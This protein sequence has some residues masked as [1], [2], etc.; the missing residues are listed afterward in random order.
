MQEQT[1]APALRHQPVGRRQRHH[2]QRQSQRSAQERDHLNE[3]KNG[4]AQSVSKN[5]VNEPS[6]AKASRVLLARDCNLELLL[7]FLNT[8]LFDNG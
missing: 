2:Q 7:G 1:L 6:I 8:T 5:N 3:K 4:A